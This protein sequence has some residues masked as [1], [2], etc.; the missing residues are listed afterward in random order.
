MSLHRVPLKFTT[1]PNCV[2]MVVP[3]PINSQVDQCT[4]VWLNAFRCIYS[5]S[6]GSR[7][8]MAVTIVRY[9]VE[10]IS[11][12]DLDQKKNIKIKPLFEILNFVLESSNVH[13]LS[14]YQS[15][16]LFIR[17]IFETQY[18]A[19]DFIPP[20]DLS[21]QVSTFIFAI[22]CIRFSRTRRDLKLCS[23]GRGMT[24]YQSHLPMKHWIT[25]PNWID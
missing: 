7:R 14:A 16:P 12:K 17:R 8:I 18:D 19:V 23:H 3:I 5:R 22:T 11:G 2:Y 24:L 15:Q 6:F 21:P 13:E 9:L 4:S 1:N 25:R 20:E 10:T